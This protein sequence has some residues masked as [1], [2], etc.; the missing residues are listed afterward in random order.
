VEASYNPKN[1]RKLI[2]SLLKSYIKTG[3]VVCGEPALDQDFQCIDFFTLLDVRNMKE[4]VM[5][6]FAVC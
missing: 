2:P 5:K 6:K 3:A 1:A 4:S